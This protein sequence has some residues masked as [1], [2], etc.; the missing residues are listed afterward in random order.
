[1]FG[2]IVINNAYHVLVQDNAILPYL[3]SL[4]E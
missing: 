2:V 1:M 3:K 4:K